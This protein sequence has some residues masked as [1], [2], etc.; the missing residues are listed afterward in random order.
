MYGD[1]DGAMVFDNVKLKS[2]KRDHEIYEGTYYIPNDKLRLLEVPMNSSL[3]FQM[4]LYYHW[5]FDFLYGSLLCTSGIY[6]LMIANLKDDPLSIVSLLMTIMFLVTE[7]F[8]LKFG[9]SGNINE[10]YPDLIA[11]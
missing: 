2:G 1:E 7:S 3:R 8:R 9:Y 6:K 4:V 5:Y 11:F 10:S